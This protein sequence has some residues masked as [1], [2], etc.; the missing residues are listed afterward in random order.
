MKIAVFG[1]RHQKKELVEKVFTLL[2]AKNVEIYIQERFHKYLTT[3][4]NLNYQFAKLI[5]DDNFSTDM[6][7]SIG[8]DGTFLRTAST[9]G[10]KNIPIIGI[11]TGRLGFLAD[12]TNDEIDTGLNDILDGKFSIEERSLLQLSTEHHDFRGFNYALNEIAVLKQ[13]SASMITAHAYINGEFLSSYQ[14][15]GLIV[16]TPTGST[17]YSLSVGGPI[18]SPTSSGFIV[19]AVASHSLTSRP[20]VVDDD[21]VI[22]LDIE[23]RNGSYLISLD[24]RSS[25]FK[26]GT[27]L[28]IKKADHKLK[29]V[30]RKGHTFY[31][32]LR[33]KLMWG[34]DPRDCK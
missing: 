1:S 31:N 34:T 2:L 4:F 15:D 11:N 17:A 9:I 27:K 3:T 6:A 14:A 19:T 12:I 22:S 33:N 23:S 16:A 32:T 24:G 29:V 7:I 26:V 30:K 5:V 28:T 8:G 21:C 10:K 18:M 13:D 25:V 20:L